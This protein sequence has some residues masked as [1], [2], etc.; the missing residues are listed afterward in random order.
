MTES[1]AARRVVI[2]YPDELGD[3]SRRQL[4]GERFRA[5]LRRSLDDLTEGMVWDEFVDVGCCGSSPDIPLRVESVDGQPR[6]GPET[7]IEYVERDAAVESGWEVQS[8]DGPPAWT[9]R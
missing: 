2:S 7:A 6:M 4:E 5:Y 9:G 8:A 1:G 3:W